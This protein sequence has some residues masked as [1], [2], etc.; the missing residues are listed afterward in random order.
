MKMV[1]CH[2]IPRPFYLVKALSQE[3]GKLHIISF[4][5][6]LLLQLVLYCSPFHFF[7]LVFMCNN[8]LLSGVSYMTDDRHT[9]AS[10]TQCSVIDSSALVM[11]NSVCIVIS[12]VTSFPCHWIATQLLF[13]QQYTEFNSIPAF[14]ISRWSTQ[15]GTWKVDMVFILNIT[16]PITNQSGMQVMHSKWFCLH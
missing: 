10:T 9:P 7:R 16:I 12:V 2:L 6:L 3:Y 4:T 15:V 1:L 5:S 14:S 13:P 8:Y 11:K